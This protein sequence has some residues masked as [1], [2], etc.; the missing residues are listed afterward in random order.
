MRKKISGKACSGN[1]ESI[2]KVAVRKLDYLLQQKSATIINPNEDFLTD[3]VSAPPTK[4]I[5]LNTIN[6]MVK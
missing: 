2:H 4:R 3:Q 6:N 5:L 1:G